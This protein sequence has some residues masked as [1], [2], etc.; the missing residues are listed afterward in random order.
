MSAAFFGTD[1]IR[2]RFG[3]PPLDRHTVVRLVR[4]LARGL[5]PGA[6]VVVGGDT[7]YST[8][9]IAGW[10][11]EALA[12][13][14]ASMRWAGVVPTPAVARL[15][16][17]LQAPVGVAI[18][19]SHN[20][21]TDNGLKLVDGA[22]F[23]WSRAAEA[24]LEAA[25]ADPP[26][27]HPE[28]V[29]TDGPPPVETALGVRYVDALARSLP[30]ETP[31]AGLRLVVDTANGAASQWA[32]ELYRRLGADVS[33]VCDAP[34][35]RNINLEC[36]STHP[37]LASHT[38]A[39]T[40]ADL[41]LTFDGDADRV[42]LVDETGAVHDGDAML[43]LWAT[44][45]FERGE[46][47]PPRIVAT[48]MSNLGL[49]R[50]LADRGIELVRCDVGDRAVVETMRREGIRLGGEQSGHL[51]HLGLSTT[52]D[53]MLTGLNLAAE[54][55][56]SGRPASALLP[57][58]ERFPQVL[59]NVRVVAKPPLEELPSVAREADAVRRALGRDGRLVLRY[60]GTEPLA[61]VMIEGPDLGTVEDLAGRLVRTIRSEIGEEELQ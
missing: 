19:A 13:E 45:L 49:T 51:V 38:T 4:H 41:G 30:G 6:D 57:G 11:A 31:L 12:G 23:K 33:A 61:R 24:A 7:R 14:G 5:T 21:W 15:T 18:S 56:A 8:V 52:G 37:E 55:A 59:E 39:E 29:A 40:G 53:G 27:A 54:I 43:Y 34:D 26:V 9:E 28:G 46:L 35:G 2:A 10:I 16:R 50:A 58:F 3:T 36:G 1:G 47:D 32:P 22:G 17:E 20:P 25:L 48:S 60:S 42:L 44:R